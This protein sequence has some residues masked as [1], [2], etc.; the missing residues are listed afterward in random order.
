[1]G[2]DWDRSATATVTSGFGADG[3]LVC[4]VDR[5]ASEA[6]AAVLAAGGNAADAAVATSAAL[7]VTTPHMCGM[8]GDLFAL[9]HTGTGPP[10]ALNASGR[11]GS[12]ADPDRLRAEGHTEMPFRGDVRASPVPGCVDGWV[13]LHGRFGR[14]PLDKVL[15]PA[16]RLAEDGFAA[17]PLFASA[18]PLLDGVVGC[19]ELTTIRPEPGDRVVRPGVARALRAVATGGRAAFYGGEF[20]DRLLEAGAGEYSADDLTAPLA[21]WVDPLGRRVWDHDVWT[22]PP[23]SQGYLALAGAAVAEAIGVPDDPDDPAWAHVLVEAARLAGFDRDEVLHDRADGDELLSGDRI[24]DRVARFDPDRTAVLG[25]RYAGGGTI[26]LCTADGEG[27]GVSLIQSNAAGFGAHVAVPG[28]GILLHNRGIGFSLRPGHPAEYRPGRRPPHTLAPVLVT[29]SDGT[30]RSVL[31]TMGGDSQPQVVLQMLTRLLRHGQRPG[32]IIAAPRYVLTT[33]GNRGFDTWKRPD[34]HIV[35][36]E[37]HAP[38]GWDEGLTARGHRVDRSKP[39]V[40]G[41]GHAHLTE[42]DPTAGTIGG[43]ADPRAMTGAAVTTA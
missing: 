28:T 32:E 26:Y 34:E 9:V 6:G 41:F 27:N 2:L 30:L 25:D 39:D 24:A 13:A 11:A 37:S 3:G 15:A 8:G 19:D 4:S 42:V 40:V 33:P 14:L 17:A 12:G 31:G 5:S 18:L 1:M 43:A 22:M 36:I 29:R 23:N 38:P 7:A 20:G 16:I 35:R 21:D 10:A